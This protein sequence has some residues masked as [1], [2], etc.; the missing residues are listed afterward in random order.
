MKIIARLEL[1]M[2]VLYYLYLKYLIVD[3][4][5]KKKNELTL[6]HINFQLK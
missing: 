6:V 5:L 4:D 2:I 1:M 3:N